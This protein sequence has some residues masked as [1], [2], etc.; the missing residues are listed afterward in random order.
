MLQFFFGRGR[1]LLSFSFFLRTTKVFFLFLFIFESTG[2][3][4]GQV[5]LRSGR[6][7]GT[8]IGVWVD[9]GARGKQS[10]ELLL[11]LWFR[12]LQHLLGHGCLFFFVLCLR[13][14]VEGCGA[15]LNL[16]LHVVVG[17]WLCGSRPRPE[18]TWTILAMCPPFF[19]CKKWKN[20]CGWS[21]GKQ[22][23][24]WS[25]SNANCTSTIP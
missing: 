24:P 4:L 12:E 14:E 23:V 18:E 10:M 15:G 9:D 5:F 8:D 1:H 25:G 2:D 6:D 22:L 13:E 7:S 20:S 19:N 17:L 21:C 3:L 16:K 11:E